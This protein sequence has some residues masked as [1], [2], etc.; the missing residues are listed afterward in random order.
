LAE[1]HLRETTD[2]NDTTHSWKQIKQ[3]VERKTYFLLFTSAN[4]AHII[5]KRSFQTE[6]DAALFVE[7][8]KRLKELSDTQFSPSYLAANN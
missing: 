6:A 2:V 8:A 5:P 7:E 1:D 3:I 4:S